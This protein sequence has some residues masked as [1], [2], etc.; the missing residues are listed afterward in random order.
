MQALGFALFGLAWLLPNH[1]PPWVNFHSEWLAFAALGC[2]LAAVLA[3]RAAAPLPG[4]ALAVGWLALVPWLQY[5]LGLVFFSGDAL[6]SSYYLLGLGL[7]IYV[8]SAD[9]GEPAASPTLLALA[10]MLWSAALASAVIGLLQWLDLT[11]YAVVFFIQADAGGRAQAN[12][13]QPNQLASLLLMGLLAL[14]YVFERRQVGLWGLLLGTAFMT[15][16]LV[17]TESRSAMLSAAVVAAW[18]CCKRHGAAQR[19][20]WQA[21]LLWFM[22]LALAMLALPWIN[23]VLLLPSGREI[24]LVDNNG[25]LAIWGQ[26]LA[27]IGQAPW[28]GYGW[29]QTAAAQAVGALAYP[30][31]LSFSNAHSL[32]LDLLAWVGVPLGAGLTGAL[33]W[34]AWSRMRRSNNVP[35]L[36]ALAMLLPVAV[37]SLLEFPFA[38]AYFLIA[39]GLLVGVVEG[40][41]AAAGL[42]GKSAPPVAPVPPVWR[43]SAWA[44][45]AGMALIGNYLSYEYLLIEEDFRVARFENL[46]VGK[47]PADYERPP[48]YLGTQLAALLAALRTPASPGMSAVQID[49]LRQVTLRFAYQPLA[50]RYALALG[51]NGDAAAASRQM[52]VVK[53]VFGPA[54]YQRATQDLRRLQQ[55]KYPQLAAVLTP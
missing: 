1:Y 30:G 31:T 47:T 55:E 14:A 36:Y 51:L 45:L 53:R 50:Y 54:Y 49:N 25:R 28:W 4:P 18:F 3:R 32:V 17:L 46:R 43:R 7:A 5:A 9:T 2:L 38:Y 10:H 19:L 34:W 26:T 33:I 27:A 48:I 11:D 15:W 6:I 44:L 23:G 35:T 22:A 39:A 37:H 42:G 20:P 41:R 24:G 29:N 8:G 40:N 52:L 13:G 12:L 16:V 21:V